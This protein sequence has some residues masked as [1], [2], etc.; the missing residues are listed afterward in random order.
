MSYFPRAN[1]K[2]FTSDS[3]VNYFSTLINDDLQWIFRKNNNETDFGIDGYIDIVTDNGEV[4]GQSI[5]VQIKS[6]ASYFKSKTDNG[7][8]YYGESKHLNYYRNQILPLLLVIYNPDDNVCLFTLFKESATE[9]SGNGWKTYV[10]KNDV[11]G[12]ESK[13]R[14][15]GFLPP[16]QDDVDTVKEHWAFNNDLTKA[17]VLLYAVGREDVEAGSVEHF[18]QFID[19]LCVNDNLY[20]KVQ[21]KVEI[22][23]DGYGLDERELSE[24]ADVIK[25][26]DV[27]EG[28]CFP[29][30]FFCNLMK[31]SSA[32]KLYFMCISGAKVVDDRPRLTG[33]QVV[34]EM[35]KKGIQPKIKVTFSNELFAAALKDNFIRLNSISDDLGVSDV[36]VEKISKDAFELL[37]EDMS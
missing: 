24:I 31:P 2:K 20:R 4:T 26:F 16:L 22:M 9:P 5:A 33:D 8:V 6:G 36:Q 14:I 21:G 35:K 15:L 23:F 11:F 37:R 1:T 17:D 18:F 12:L 10:N 34:D 29:W 25:W 19:R 3:G 7:Y 13:N 28:R 32:L 30:F 27:V